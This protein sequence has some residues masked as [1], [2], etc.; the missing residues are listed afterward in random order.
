MM[1]AAP[2]PEVAHAGL[3]ALRMVAAADGE[4]HDLERRFAGA[5]QTHILGTS[6]DF[7]GLEPIDPEELARAVPEPFRE[8]IVHGCLLAALIDG[9]ASESEVA[10]VDAFAGALGV[11]RDAIRTAEK[12]VDDQLVGFRID[13]LRRSFLG[14]RG[15]DFVKRRGIRGLLSVAANM[16]QIENPAMAARYRALE[17][18]PV[19][20]LGRGYWE[21]TTKNGFSLPGEKGAGPEPIVFHDCL[22][23]LAEYDTSSIEETQIAAF[24]AGT[25]KKDAVYGMLFPL[26]QFHLGVSITPVTN[27]ERGVID[28]DL[29]IKAF[30]RGT[31]TNIDL[32][33]SWQPWDDFDRPVTE[34]RL[35]YGIEPRS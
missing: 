13:I 8:R 27:A 28:P 23:V 15:V 18:A 22:H 10:L 16:M 31:K 2:P 9:E 17:H 1:L 6:F 32:A 33:T 4:I 12:L 29:W 30:V 19:G 26:A 25:L 7:D 5:V 20:T 34:L 11:S 3:R 24:Q 21:F 14:Q 35:A